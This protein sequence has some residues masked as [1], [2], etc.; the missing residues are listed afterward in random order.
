MF[1]PWA[2][3]FSKLLRSEIFIFQQHVQYKKN[4]L[5]NKNYIKSPNGH[6]PLVIPVLKDKSSTTIFNKTIVDYKWL[7]K[8]LRLISD[9]YKRSEYFKDVYPL[10]E[11]HYSGFNNQR[12]SDILKNNVCF[13]LDYLEIPITVIESKPSSNVGSNL[14]L[15]QVLSHGSKKY[16]SG[17]GG[18]NYLDFTK[19][20]SAGIEI[21]VGEYREV[22]YAQVKHK[23]NPGF[24]GGMS[25]LDMMFNL[26]REE[27]KEF[28]KDNWIV[29][30]EP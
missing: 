28:L 4:S 30:N 20:K 27:I 17:V 16:V 6:S 5:I 14:V 9:S 10:V 12:F 11:N 2:G 3:Y 21:E 24:A 8:H 18:L 29:I 13:I 25:I 15:D 23:N 1:W 19:F 26:R 7:S 22:E